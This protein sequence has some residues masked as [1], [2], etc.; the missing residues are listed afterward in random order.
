MLVWADKNIERLKAQ[1]AKTKRKKAAT[2]K[3][4][5]MIPN[6]SK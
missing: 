4:S 3:M 2:K 1:M 5:G 6:I